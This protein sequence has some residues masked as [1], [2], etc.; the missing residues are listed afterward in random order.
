[1]FLSR[2]LIPVLLLF[3]PVSP[4]SYRQEIENWRREREARLKAE[5]GWLTVVG[6]FW[7]KEGSNTVG[8]DPHSDIVLP[9]GSAPASVGEFVFEKGEVR[10]VSAAGVP[11]TVNGKPAGS[12][13]MKPDTSGSPDLL[14][15]NSLTMFV[16]QRGR[17][18]GIRLKDSNS[19]ARRTFTGLEYFPIRERYR[20]KARY[21][22]YDSPRKITIPNV[23]GE[24]SEEVSP[25]YVEFILEGKR[26]RLEPMLEGD[27]LFFIF[28]DRTAARET[29]PAGRF[30]YA[31]LPKGGEVILDFNK[32]INPPCAFTPYA[33]CPLPPRQNHLAVRIEAG[34]R[35][36]G[37]ARETAAK[38]H[39]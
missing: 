27:Q 38:R 8:T 12:A 24:A 36:Y 19:A 29:Y 26:C 15:I 39:R 20:V 7:L 3:M 28:K 33:T 11:A 2:V 31:G 23:L 5:D 16:I 1:L 21:Q 9:Q 30:L 22:P 32:A 14:R 4:P 37:H 17:R 34:E 35:R 13:R 10:F 25:G 6:L 18:T